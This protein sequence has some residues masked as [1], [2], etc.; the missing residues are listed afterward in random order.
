M[1]ENKDQIWE[2]IWTEVVGT[3]VFVLFILQVT[4]KKTAPPDLGTFGVFGIVL[5]LWALCNVVWYPGASFNPALA[6]GCSIFQ[7]WHWDIA[8]RGILLFYMPWY[9]VGAFAGGAAAGMFHWFLSSLYPD[10]G[11]ERLL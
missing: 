11:E 9:I 7:Y 1:G 2:V 4:G 6:I 8:N 10:K 5:N 3:F